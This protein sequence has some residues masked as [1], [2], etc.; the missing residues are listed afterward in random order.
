M[1]RKGDIDIREIVFI[2][3]TIMFVGALW[4][5]YQ[6]SLDNAVRNALL[7]ALQ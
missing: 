2:A 6:N 7:Q 1:I 3:I 5:V 4:M